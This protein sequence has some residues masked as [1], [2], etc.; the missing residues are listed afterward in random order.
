MF[1]AG[2][3]TR[4]GYAFGNALM[5]GQ[6]LTLVALAFVV[7]LLVTTLTLW[8][9]YKLMKLS[10]GYL[11]GLTAGM[12]T[13]PAILSFATEQSKNETPNLGYASSYP[14]AMIS[15][16]VIAQIILSMLLK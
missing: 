11:M 8:V 3:G 1:M 16:I 12:F 5:Q 2:V 14:M 13:Q 6:A 15:K 7:S 9:G 4:S 10:Y